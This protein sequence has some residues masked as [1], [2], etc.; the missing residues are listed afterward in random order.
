MK[1]AH[2]IRRELKLEG[3]YHAQMKEALELAWAIKNGKVTYEEVVGLEI[4]EQIVP[5]G[6][7]TLQ[8]I[9]KEH[10]NKRYVA[11]P[12]ADSYT[13]VGAGKVYEYKSMH[14]SIVGNQ[15]AMYSV[16]AGEADGLLKADYKTFPVLNKTLFVV[17]KDDEERFK[18]ALPKEGSGYE[19]IVCD[20][21]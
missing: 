6:A 3:H 11:Y 14:Q 19:F 4:E 15:N 8:D 1:L 18:D 20:C 16:Y 21:L 12:T 13:F 2:K 7:T 9:I 10:S 17:G 5:R